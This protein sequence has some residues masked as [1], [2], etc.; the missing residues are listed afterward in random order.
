MGINGWYSVFGKSAVAFKD[1][2]FE[3]KIIGIDV[4]YEIYRASLGA[5]NIKEL[6]D[7]DG[8]PTLLL[9]T[10]LCNVVKYRKLN[11]KGFLYIFDNPEPNPLKEKEIKKRKAYK[12]KKDPKQTE[13]K[14]EK[15]T[16]T[17]TEEMIKDVKKML[18]FMGLCW[19]VAPKGYEA[20]QIGASFINKGFIDLLITADSDALLFGAKSF[21]RRVK[22]K[23]KSKKTVLEE[24]KLGKVLDDFKLTRDELVHLSVILGSDFADKTKGIGPKTV[25]KKGLKIE[26]T[27]E[28][29]IAKD[30]FMNDCP[31]HLDDIKSNEKNIKGLIKWLVDDKNFNEDRLNKLLKE[32]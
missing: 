1:S 17:I 13:Q 2:D 30:Y 32:F 23:Q 25:L 27:K 5:P 9:N 10:L 24:Y 14:R 4:S 16:F 3:N 20:E 6:T 7:K 19:I 12:E 28:Q 18:G 31:C 11:V 22:V 8:N 21:V 29:Q 15:R 26:L